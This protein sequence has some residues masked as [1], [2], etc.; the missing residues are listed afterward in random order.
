MDVDLDRGI[1][2]SYPL[3]GFGDR[4]IQQ[5]RVL[6]GLSLGRRQTCQHDRQ[7]LVRIAG[8]FIAVHRQGF[9]PVVNVVVQAFSA[10]VGTQMIHPFVTRN[11]VQPSC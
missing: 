4:Q 2:L 9:G 7:V 10:T 6:D 5:P 11:C 1:T 8:V 3:G